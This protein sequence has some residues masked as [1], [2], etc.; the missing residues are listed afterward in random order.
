MKSVKWQAQYNSA[1]FHFL[2]FKPGSLRGPS[3]VSF[4]EITFGRRSVRLVCTRLSVSEDDKKKAG[5]RQAGSDKDTS[6][7]TTQKSDR[8]SGKSVAK[9]QLSVLGQDSNLRI[10]AF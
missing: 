6:F 4:Y 8:N 2:A 9:R 7:S 5:A 10:F 1:A 3:E